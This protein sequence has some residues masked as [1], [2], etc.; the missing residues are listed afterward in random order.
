MQTFLR[1]VFVAI[2]VVV[3]LMFLDTEGAWAEPKKPDHLPTSGKMKSLTPRQYL[4]LTYPNEAEVL[5]AVASC[6]SAWE[7]SAKNP[8]SSATGLF[9]FIDGTWE[10]VRAEMGRDGSLDVRFEARENIDSAVFL[11]RLEGLGPWES[12]RGCWEELMQDYGQEHQ[13]N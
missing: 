7:P 10:W 4:Y 8:G 3:A 12:S 2:L 6:E 1:W 5:D 9:Q 13:E 11:Y